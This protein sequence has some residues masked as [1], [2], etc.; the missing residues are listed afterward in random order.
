MSTM[1]LCRLNTCIRSTLHFYRQKPTWGPVWR[2]ELDAAGGQ[3]PAP[4][5][6]DGSQDLV[7]TKAYLKGTGHTG[8]SS[9]TVLLPPHPRLHSNSFFIQRFLMKKF[10]QQAMQA[11]KAVL[12]QRHTSQKHGHLGSKSALLLHYR[13][14]TS[15]RTAASNSNILSSAPHVI[16][17]KCQTFQMLP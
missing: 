11:N 6:A 2:A 13:E 14:L 10:F 3:V 4:T 15:H 8:S 1:R 16:L 9:H 17:N 5:P 12:C 7:T